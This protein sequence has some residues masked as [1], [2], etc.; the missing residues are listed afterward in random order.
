MKDLFILKKTLVV[1]LSVFLSLSVSAQDLNSSDQDLQTEIGL[2]KEDQAFYNALYNKDCSIPEGTQ[3]LHYPMFHKTPSNTPEVL[4]NM[5]NALN[6]EDTTSYSQWGVL[7]LIRQYPNALVFDEAFWTEEAIS[8]SASDLFW[9]SV[10]YARQ[11]IIDGNYDDYMETNNTSLVEYI[12]NLL[13]SQ[14]EQET[15]IES[16]DE[17]LLYSSTEEELLERFEI[18]TAYEDLSSLGKKILYYGGTQVALGLGVIDRIYPTTLFSSLD[19]VRTAYWKSIQR[20]PEQVSQRISE[21]NVELLKTAGQYNKETSVTKK[22]EIKESFRVLF[23]ERQYLNSLQKG[24]IFKWREHLLFK[25]VSKVLEE[26]SN[27]SR[28]VIIPYG[29]THDFSDDFKDYNFYQLPYACSIPTEEMIS[30]L[31][32]I[33]LLPEIKSK[34]RRNMFHQFIRSNLQ[35]ASDESL[36]KVSV[37]LMDYAVTAA[38]A[39][40]SIEELRENL[41]AMLDDL[42]QSSSWEFLFTQY[43]SMSDEEK[44]HAVDLLTFQPYNVDL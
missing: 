26:A 11:N 30:N 39:K 19:E 25:S 40:G 36:E 7:Q 33:G 2:S 14:E 29:F 34:S 5:L 31:F 12:Y 23:E 13:F 22:D 24:F 32:F 17:E 28:M 44:A 3:V 41:M 38:N 16:T 15:N 9:Q 27:Q 35:R 43:T 6:I 8:Q 10:V 20:D 37:A 4:R 42:A 1:L 21:L 18:A